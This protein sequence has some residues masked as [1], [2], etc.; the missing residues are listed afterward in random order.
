MAD[1][2]TVYEKCK[3]LRLDPHPW[4]P[5]DYN[6]EFDTSQDERLIIGGKWDGGYWCPGG[7]EIKLK[8]V[9]GCMIGAQ[10]V[11]LFDHEC[12]DVW[13]EVTE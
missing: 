13:V 7:R 1:I 11:C 2:L 9:H 4:Y 8:Q 10:Q 5:H 3:H 6:R 12:E